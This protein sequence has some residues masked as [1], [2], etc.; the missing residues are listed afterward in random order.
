M[1]APN[2]CEWSLKSGG[3][4]SFLLYGA[5]S[6]ICPNWHDE[7]KTKQRFRQIYQTREEGRFCVL[8]IAYYGETEMVIWKWFHDDL[9]QIKK[10]THGMFDRM[11]DFAPQYIDAAK[12]WNETWKVI[13]TLEEEDWA[14]QLGNLGLPV[15]VATV[16]RRAP[17]TS[18]GVLAALGEVNMSMARL[19]WHATMALENEGGRWKVWGEVGELP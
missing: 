13:A 5:M 8:E 17:V 14:T 2:Q 11:N 3:Q 12:R 15:Y 19:Q 16:A 6:G 1:S 10:N 9:S 4:T 18:E 7:S